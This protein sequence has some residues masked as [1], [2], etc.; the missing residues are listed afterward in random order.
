[1]LGSDMATLFKRLLAHES[2]EDM[3]DE[4]FLPEN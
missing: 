2:R 4:Y 3:F 1:V